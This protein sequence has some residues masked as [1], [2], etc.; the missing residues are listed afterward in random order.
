MSSR[1]AIIGSGNSTGVPWL[2]CAI[3]KDYRCQVCQNCLDNPD[4]RNVRNNVSSI[5]SYA[6]PDGRT[7]HILIDVGKTFRSTVMRQFEKLGISRLDAVILT[8][9]HADAMNGLDDL[10]DVSPDTRLPV[11]CSEVTFKRIAASFEYLVKGAPIAGLFIAQLDW[12]IVRP[13]EPFEVEGL[14]VTPLPVE[15]GEPGPMLAFEFWRT[16]PAAATGG[17][18]AAV[19]AVDAAAQPSAASAGSADSASP[20]D[21][22]GTAAGAPAGPAAAASAKGQRIVYISDIAALPLDTRAYLQSGPPIDL[23]VIDALSYRSY[24][25]HFS[26]KQAVACGLDLRAARTVLVG[27]NH[28]IDHYAEAPKLEGFGAARGLRME[29]AYDGWSA[30]VAL[31]APAPRSAIIG[32]LCAALATASADWCEGKVAVATTA[33]HVCATMSQT[34]RLCEVLPPAVLKDPP[35]YR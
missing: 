28:R 34:A 16:V 10:R 7:R 11:Y 15:H 8:H 1:F 14:Q 30:D 19:Q 29:L 35:T 13:F 4:S 20:A 23:A 31:D 5:V 27:M 22:S 21:A 25:T 32:D 18:G 12:R 6:H 3:N 17:A 33:D 9:P 24:P 26:L 2:Y